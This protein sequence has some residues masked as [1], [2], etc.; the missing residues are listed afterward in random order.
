MYGFKDIFKDL[1][2]TIPSLYQY[3]ENGTKKYKLIMNKS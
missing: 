3:F 2:L 1:V